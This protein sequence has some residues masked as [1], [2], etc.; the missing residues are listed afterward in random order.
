MAVHR[1]ACVRQP[2][3]SDCGPA[4]LATISVHYGG[5]SASQQMRDIAGTDRIGT[6]LV[7]MI[8]AAERMGFMAKAVKARSTCCPRRP[9]PGHRPR[10]HQ[11]GPGPF[12]RAPP[13]YEDD[14]SSPPIRGGES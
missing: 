13:S 7:G 10:S 5:R 14:G 11:R 9:L 6:N 4:C 8:Q 2:D 3:Q 1:W 12:R